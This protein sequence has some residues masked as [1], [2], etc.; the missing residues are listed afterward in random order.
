[1]R[2]SRSFAA[3]STPPPPTA[4]TARAQ[5]RPT[6]Q[7]TAI[8]CGNGGVRFP[9]RTS[10]FRHRPAH[11]ST[12]SPQIPRCK[13]S[14]KSSSSGRDAN[15]PALSFAST[16]VTRS[17]SSGANSGGARLPPSPRSP[18]P[19]QHSGR[20]GP[21]VCRANPLHRHRLPLER[22]ALRHIRRD[23]LPVPAQF[24]SLAPPAR[25]T[26]RAADSGCLSRRSPA[27]R[28]SSGGKLRQRVML[29]CQFIGHR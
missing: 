19:L 20:L 7:H 15:S 13:S 11:S 10:I 4:V 27:A 6:W 23:R 25:L 21:G 1:M 24:D 14:T 17:A 22:H 29:S 5:P 16:R 2:P 28:F 18:S 26:L 3:G 9:T 8:S 12:R